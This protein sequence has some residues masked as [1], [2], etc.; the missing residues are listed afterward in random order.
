MQRD[1]AESLGIATVADLASHASAL[2]LGTD[3]E[4]LSR[5][6]WSAI[7]SAYGFDFGTKRSFD[8]TFMY[9]ALADGSVDVISAF[10][11]DGR[12][13]AQNLLVLR[14]DKH[15]L[16]P[17]DALILV[18]PKRA[19]DTTLIGA[20][21]PLLGKISVEKMRESELDGRSQ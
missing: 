4:F 8:P 13:A 10:S 18:S 1:R 9:R 5:P 6:E 19:K 2:T 11:S 17:Y 21:T 16:P 3:F 15:V 14:D 12:I 7:K 20:L